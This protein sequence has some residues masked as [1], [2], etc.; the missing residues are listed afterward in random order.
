MKIY[1]E[2]TT[3]DGL[4]AYFQGLSN[5]TEDIDFTTMDHLLTNG[6][7]VNATCETSGECVMHQRDR[8]LFTLLRGMTQCRLCR[9]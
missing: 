4:L 9:Y 2:C 6:A 1:T 7:D 5:S 3:L 8:P